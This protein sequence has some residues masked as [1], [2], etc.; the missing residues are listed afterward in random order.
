MCWFSLPCTSLSLVFTHQN[1][2]M[3]WTKMLAEATLLQCSN[4]SSISR[5]NNHILNIWWVIAKLIFKCRLQLQNLHLN[6]RL[7]P[8]AALYLSSYSRAPDDRHVHPD[9]CQY[10]GFLTLIALLQCT[11][12]NIL[13]QRVKEHVLFSFTAKQPQYFR[14][15]ATH[16]P[17]NTSA[18]HTTPQHTVSGHEMERTARM[19]WFAYGKPRKH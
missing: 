2:C 3:L 6:P 9:F 15:H 5:S 12:V 13:T 8:F 7:Q 18:Q 4:C 10:S 19:G 17:H 1:K 11:T 14:V 16:S